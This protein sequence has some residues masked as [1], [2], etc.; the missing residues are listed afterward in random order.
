M[1]VKPY[2][3]LYPTHIVGDWRAPNGMI[4]SICPITAADA[5]L[6]GEFVRS[7]SSETRYLRFMTAVNGL[8][9]RT[10]DRLTRVNHLHDAA[11]I[12]IVKEASGH[13]VAGVGRYALNADG[14]SCE[15]AI[16][17]ADDWLG[18]GL[19]RRL[20]TLLIDTAAERELKRIAGDVLAI[21]EPMIAFVKALGFEVGASHDPTMRRVRLALDRYCAD[22]A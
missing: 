19:G 5:E 7:L 11:L 15:F 13:R 16:V 18:L 8:D 22:A 20:L 17:V 2:G 4:V 6:I 12:A 21:N 1:Q 10:M 3:N 14:E 9:P